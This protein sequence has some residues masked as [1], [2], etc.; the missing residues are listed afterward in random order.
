MLL[1]VYQDLLQAVSKRR[2]TALMSAKNLTDN[3][4]I[5]SCY[6]MMIPMFLQIRTNGVLLEWETLNSSN[7]SCQDHLLRDPGWHTNLRQKKKAWTSMS[8][9]CGTEIMPK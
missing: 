9:N 2:L 6:S 4:H 5:S 3:T 1:S 8:K 7:D